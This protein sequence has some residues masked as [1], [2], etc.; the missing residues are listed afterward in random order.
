MEKFVVKYKIAMFG[1]A[2]YTT[3]EYTTYEVAKS[4]ADDIGG[5]E[6]VHSVRIEPVAEAAE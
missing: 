6:G 2:E 1:E 3:E 4:H 5:F